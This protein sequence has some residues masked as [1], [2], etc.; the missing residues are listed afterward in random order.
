M[1]SQKDKLLEV[2]TWLYT[3][4]HAFANKRDWRKALVGKLHYLAF[5]DE[6][7]EQ[8]FRK[9]IIETMEGEA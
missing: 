7:I 8:E 4:D 6:K 2:I 1:K 9:N 3:D 5:D